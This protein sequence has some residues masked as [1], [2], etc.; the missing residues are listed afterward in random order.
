MPD[1]AADDRVVL[2]LDA[3]GTNFVFCAMAGHEPVTE[4]LTLP[5]RADDLDASLRTMVDGFERTRAAAPRPP[6]AISFAFPGPCDYARGIVVGPPN[7]TAY[8]NVAVGPMLEDRFGL[9]VFINND[10]DLF[11]VGEAAAGLLPYVN[12]LLE[13]AGSPKRYHNLVGF[14]IGTGFGCGIVRSGELY[15]GDNSL[16]GEVWL[17]RNKLVP[18]TN[19]EEGVSIRAVRNAYA[20][21]AGVPIGDVPEP[22]E[23]AAVAR[24]EAPGDAEAARRAFA[25]LG[26][27]AGDAIAFVTTLLDALVVIG[28][29]I[30]AAHRLF[31]P[32][33]VAEMNGQYRTPA[34]DPFRRLVQAAFDLEDPQQLQTFLRGRPIDLRV[35]G[36]GRTVSFDS[37]QRV[38][39]GITRL[40]T[41]HATAIGAYAHAL[42]HLPRGN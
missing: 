39:V 37:L 13:Q 6:V 42:N 8:R 11:A 21:L 1:Y 15:V 36:S 40:G 5:A 19:V 27:V 29:G 16:G 24:G 28:G 26:E 35:P 33:L 14:T 41:S 9:P 17:L 18:W 12:G 22:R 38:G 34:G 23:I 25:Q 3:G 4:P 31:L 2:T 10:G 32:A 20:S 7:L 30:A